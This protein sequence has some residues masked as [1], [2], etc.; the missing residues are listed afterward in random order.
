MHRLYKAITPSDSRVSFGV[1]YLLLWTS[2]A[3]L[4]DFVQSVPYG[5]VVFCIVQ[6]YAVNAI[7]KFWAHQLTADPN[8]QE[9]SQLL[10]SRA[11][12]LMISVL[13]PIAFSWIANEKLAASF[14]PAGYWRDEY[15]RVLANNCDPFRGALADLAEELQVAQNK[16]QRGL[17]TSRDVV[18]SAGALSR[19]SDQLQWC[20][21]TKQERTATAS[22]HLMRLQ[23]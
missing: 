19:V 16:H 8:N 15:Q 9:L 11:S 2:A 5:V 17:A 6:T 13:A 22:S 18:E 4:S 3:G 21:R 10:K 23:N 12:I 1:G 14:N 20:E 7:Y